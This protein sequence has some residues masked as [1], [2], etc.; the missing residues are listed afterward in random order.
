MEKWNIDNGGS[1]FRLTNANISTNYS[2]SNK[3]K[4]DKKGDKNKREKPTGNATGGRTDDLFG[5]SRPL[6]E[7]PNRKHKEG[8]E[9]EG[10]DKK[11]KFYQAVIPWDLTL[12]HSLTYSNMAREGRIANNSLMFSGNVSL[13]PKW[14]V[15]VSSGYDFVNKGFTYTQLRFERDLDSFRMSFQFTPFGYRT[16]WYFFIGIKAS[17]LSD[18]KWEKNKQPD[19]VL[20]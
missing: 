10:D 4:Q 9:G 17:M 3:D 19:R 12:A 14:Q 13:T 15:G 7:E 11:P 5:S 1:L 6:N 2:F 16:S 18:L 20:R 8:E